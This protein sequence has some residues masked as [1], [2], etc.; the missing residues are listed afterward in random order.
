MNRIQEDSLIYTGVHTHQTTMSG[1]VVVCESIYQALNAF[2]EGKK[3]HFN[4]GMKKLFITSFDH[5]DMPL[6]ERIEMWKRVCHAIAWHKEFEDISI[7]T[8]I[9]HE[10]QRT[11][12]RAVASVSTLKLLSFSGVSFFDD[13]SEGIRWYLSEDRGITNFSAHHCSC[14]PEL[15]VAIARLLRNQRSLTGVG[16][17]G[18]MLDTATYVALCESIHELPVRYLTLFGTGITEEGG[19]AI[20]DLIARHQKLKSIYE[21][22]TDMQPEAMTAIIG[23]FPKLRTLM[24]FS[25]GR[26][27]DD[28]AMELLAEVLA[29]NPPL[30]RLH[31]R[32]Q[33]PA[34]E[35]LC[36]LFRALRTNTTLR[37]LIIE[38]RG[39]AFPVYEEI[40]ALLRSNHTALQFLTFSL[41][42]KSKVVPFLEM[43]DTA[44]SSNVTVRQIGFL[45]GSYNERSALVSGI[46]EK[47]GRNRELRSNEDAVDMLWKLSCRL[48][49][50]ILLEIGRH[51]FVHATMADLDR[52][53]DWLEWMKSHVPA[54]GGVPG[55]H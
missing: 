42:T 52:Y 12:F 30:K 9:P 33:P 50:E 26:K 37:T 32:F 5:E 49:R 31:F 16:V 46:W 38:G 6:P 11:F 4:P 10:V 7:F 19:R 3:F 18:D 41:P 48:P 8:G 1:E 39:A 22:T 45:S 13:S 54:R 51:L 34:S 36:A 28:D 40:C 15:S 2:R 24:R 23:A 21:L 53:M 14:S 43:L 44:M 25:F 29:K 55:M 47:I 27:L 35:S 20:A 17:I